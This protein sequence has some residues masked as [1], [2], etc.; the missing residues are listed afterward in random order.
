MNAIAYTR[1]STEDQAIGGVGLDMQ[2][3]EIKR[4][5]LEL[6]YTLR[7]WFTDDGVSGSK[8][9]RPGLD[10]ALLA[11]VPGEA[12]FVHARDRLF[13][14]M[15]AAANLR[16]R[17]A[18][19][20]NLIISVAD[21][22]DN[23]D[24]ERGTLESA[25]RFLAG[26]VKDLIAHYNRLEIKARVRQGMAQC[27]TDN[28]SVGGLPFG[29][30]AVRTDREGRHGRFIVE[31]VPNEDEQHVLNQ[32][33]LRAAQGESLRSMAAWLNDTG[34]KTKRGGKWHAETVKSLLAAAARRLETV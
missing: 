29:W 2:R 32:L 4:K 30:D 5:A 17:F 15:G 6:G 25:S 11:L 21:G 22:I 28:R 20:G 12:L 16:K 10:S 14:N 31:I 24:E 9:Q 19:S 26:G 3:A 1:V 8:E 18:K 13:R 7:L 33:R 23:C 27:I 34:V